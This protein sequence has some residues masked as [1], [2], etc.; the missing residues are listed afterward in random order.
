MT[1]FSDD[2]PATSDDAAVDAPAAPS[3]AVDTEV[4]DPEA[5]AEASEAEAEAEAE[6]DSGAND[7]DHTDD[8]VEED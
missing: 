1:S 6:A 3:G 5:A 2:T 7:T 4:L 8:E